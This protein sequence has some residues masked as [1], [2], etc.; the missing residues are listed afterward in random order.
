MTAN[1]VNQIEQVGGRKDHAREKRLE[2]HAHS[3]MS[4]LDGV[5]SLKSVISTAAKWGHKAIAIT[6]HGVVQA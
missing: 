1:D 2:L 3:P 6:D 5:A 4:A